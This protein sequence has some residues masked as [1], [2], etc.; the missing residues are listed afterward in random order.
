MQLV[1]QLW[2]LQVQSIAKSRHHQHG[3]DSCQAHAK[4]NTSKLQLVLV[5]GVLLTV[6][7]P[8]VYDHAHLTNED[9]ATARTN[10]KQHNAQSMMVTTR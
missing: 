4:S 2:Q 1:H 6:G 9:W 10:Y 8:L 5:P 3:Q 7:A